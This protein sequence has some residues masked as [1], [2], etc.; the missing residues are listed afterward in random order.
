MAELKP[1]QTHWVR[2]LAMRQADTQYLEWSSIPVRA[3]AL[4][5]SA[6]KKPCTTSSCH[7]SIGPP[8][9]HRFQVSRRRRRVIGSMTAAGP[10]SDRQLTLRARARPACGPARRRFAELPSR[11]VPGAS[12][13]PWLRQQARFD[14]GSELVG[15][16]D[17]SGLPVRRLRSAPA[18]GASSAE[19]CPS[20]WPPRPPSDHRQL[21]PAPPCTSAQSR[22]SPSCV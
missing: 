11:N 4:P 1:S 17:Y 22:S 18:T 5:P 15:A 9:S 12:R 14:E 10:D 21:P 2:S 16:S 8:R 6:S 3:L 13:A 19:R 7:S 20:P